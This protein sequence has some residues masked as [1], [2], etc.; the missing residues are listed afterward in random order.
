[1]VTAAEVSALDHIYPG[2]I[3]ALKHIDLVLEEGSKVAII[4]QNG[5]GKTTLSKHFNGLLRPARGK[6]FVKGED[7]AKKSVGE[8][9][10]QVG[11]V[12]QNPNYQLFS[13]N[14]RDEIAFG[15]RNLNMGETKIRQRTTRVLKEFDLTALA[16]LPPLSLSSGIRKIIALA[17]V[18]A[19]DPAILFLDEPTTG[20]DH[21]GKARIGG[22]IADLTQSGHTVV[23]ITHDMN[24]AARYVDRVIVMAAGE[25]I[26]DASPGKIFSD[27]LIMSRAHVKAPQSIALIHALRAAGEPVK[28][29][30]LTPDQAAR[31]LSERSSHG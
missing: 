19:M 4:G 21:G 8:L 27:P 12:F 29:A 20:Q 25:I 24:F 6:V 31:A 30:P 13:S 5:S 23:I 26:A 14:V 17:S 18:Y 11:Y 16:E 22:L 1:M 2:N 15:L 7:T 3:Y 10:R 28:G 9:A